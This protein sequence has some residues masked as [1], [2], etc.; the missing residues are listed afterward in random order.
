[1]KYRSSKWYAGIAHWFNFKYLWVS[2]LA[3]GTHNSM[4]NYRSL[5]KSEK[6]LVTRSHKIRE[7]TCHAVT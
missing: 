1:M 2:I 5:L 4:T 6:I 7:D 3:D